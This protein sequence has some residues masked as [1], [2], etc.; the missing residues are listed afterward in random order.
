MTPVQ[1]YTDE[2]V[3]IRVAEQLRRH[4]I[5]TISTADANNLAQSDNFQ[6]EWAATAGRTFVTHNVQDFARLHYE[7][8]QNNR[9]HSGIVLAAQGGIGQIVRRLRSIVVMFD[10]D[11]MR[12]RLEYLSNWPAA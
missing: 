5:D 10:R 12:N 2:D 4:G 7:W 1:F 8:M 6:L 9:S 3:S 11:A